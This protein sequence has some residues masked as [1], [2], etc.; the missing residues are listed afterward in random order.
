MNDKFLSNDLFWK[1]YFAVKKKLFIFASPI[2]TTPLND[3]YHGG[4]SFFY[5]TILIQH[6]KKASSYLDD[7]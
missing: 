2:P 4:T 3:A 1:K 5:V 6:T 7:A